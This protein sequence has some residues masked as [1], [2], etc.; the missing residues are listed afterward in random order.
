MGRP[1]GVAR[2]DRRPDLIPVLYLDLDSFEAINNGYGHE[3]GDRLL[4]E[5]AGRL[6]SCVRPQDAAAR[7]QQAVRL[8]LRRVFRLGGAHSRFPML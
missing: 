1:P 6:K 8:Q 3:A 4:V 2:L 7:H 5:V